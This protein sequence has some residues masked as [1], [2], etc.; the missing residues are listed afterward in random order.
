[1]TAPGLFSAAL[2]GFLSFISPCVLPL[3]PAYLSFISGSTAA[4]LSAGGSKKK[5]FTASL[6][7]TAGFTA[8]FTLLGIVFS[9]AARLA[10]EALVW[11]GAAGGIVVVLLGLNL[12]FDFLKFL[13]RDNRLIAKFTGKKTTNPGGAFLLG[14]AFAAGWSPCI[15]PIL[16]SILLYAGKEENVF[17]AALLLLAYSFGFALPFLAAGHF[18]DRL[19]PLLAFFARHG[20]MVRIVSGIVLIV[21]GGAMAAGSLGSV[22]ALAYRLGYGLRSFTHTNRSLTHFLGALFWI[23]SGAFAA[24]SALPPRRR[25]LSVPRLIF[26]AVCAG[27]A[28]LEI[29]GVFST[30][31]IIASWLGFTGI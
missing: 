25:R 12:V 24:A 28:V 2:A 26:I 11:I 10:G 22:S 16:A 21:L 20:K 23:A 30:L 4:E 18:F 1:M 8:A 27:A 13:D 14:L 31:G 9:G 15:G 3:V 17:H 19:K 7:F 29:A 5:V 6:A